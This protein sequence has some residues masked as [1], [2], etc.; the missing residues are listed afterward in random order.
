MDQDQ[1]DSARRTEHDDTTPPTSD[2]RAETRRPPAALFVQPPTP[3]GDEA[4]PPPPRPLAKPAR[5]TPFGG[6]EPAPSAPQTHR[7]V[8][9]ATAKNV[10]AVSTRV[11]E[12]ASPTSV[13]V[14]P[15]V[16][17][18]AKT[19]AKKAAPK[20]AAPTAVPEPKPAAQKTTAARKA[21]AVQ[22]STPVQKATATKKTP[23]AKKTT[24]PKK[25]TGAS[26]TKEANPEEDMP[27]SP[28]PPPPAPT[29]RELPTQADL[30]AA[31][32]RRPV[33]ISAALALAAVDHYASSAREQADWLRRTYPRVEPDRLVRIAIR[34]ATQRARLATGTAIVGG[35][36]GA[37]AGFT[38]LTWARSRLVLDV[39]AIYGV[40]PADPERAVDVLELLRIYPD[41][42]SATR[43]VI[44][45][46]DG[47]TPPATESTESRTGTSAPKAR[48]ALRLAARLV[49]GAGLVL[50]GLRSV[51]E[52]EDLARRTTR[53]YRDAAGVSDATATG[54]GRAG[55]A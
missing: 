6:T 29:A 39:A 16:P 38:A 30:W 53:F 12:V 24:A 34:T 13:P 35:P 21:T 49:P 47:T 45:I 11:F 55:S 1:T 51:A 50:D 42:E 18:A 36:V 4:P 3:P 33:L 8:E 40:D 2:R 44:T 28:T 48:L 32:R 17:K 5:T 27:E 15:A 19:A 41:R 46:T 31:V 37:T 20:K 22:E 7:K 52:T 10:P 25:A 23:V 43:A 26:E 9:P 14:V 54:P